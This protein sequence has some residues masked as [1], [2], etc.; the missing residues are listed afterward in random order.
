VD[1]SCWVQPPQLEWLSL[2][3][4]EQWLWLVNAWLA[5]ERAPSLVGQPISGP[6]A[7]AAPHRAS[8]GTTINALSA[9]AQRP[10]APVVRKRILEIL[11]ELS[12]EAAA[13]DGKAPVLDAAAVLQ[14]AEWTQPRMARRFSSLIRGVLAE[15][16]LLG[17]IGSGALSQLGAAIAAERPDEALDIL[18][19][20][21]PAALNHVLLQADLTAVA[22]GYLAPELSE[23]L[24]MMADAE[25]QGPATIYRFSVASIRRALDAGQD[26]A[27]LLG[28][29]REH[30]ATAVPQPLEYL[31]EDTAARHGRLRVGKASSFIQSDDE[32]ALVELVNES[33][34]A[35]LGLVRIA[36]TV[37]ISHAGPKETA[38]VLRGLGLSPA[39]E[40]AESALVR[41]RRTTAVPG[42][43]RPVYSAPRIAPPEAD[44]AAQLAVLRSSKPSRGVSSNGDH[45]AAGSAGEVATQLGLETLQR[46]IRLKQAVTM[47]VV[48]SEGNSSRETVVPVSVTG[49]RVRVFDPARETERVLSIHRIIDIEAEEELRQ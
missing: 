34:A 29:L 25:G 27:T 28:F 7:G 18:G 11:N 17:L 16:E 41:L 44:V 37:L 31:V 33:N 10:D 19:E 1:S 42:S 32:A 22:P 9:E 5:S 43:G 26:A 15:A 14:R 35:V 21:L 36:P 40:E 24:L 20:H 48:D 12:L 49:G 2:P 38:Q 8:A 46:A 4:Q 23:K 30:S 47:N 3:R 6:G 13:A 39:V 45:R